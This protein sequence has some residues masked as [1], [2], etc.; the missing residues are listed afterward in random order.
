MKRKKR[1]RKK[2]KRFLF[3]ISIILLLFLL[4]Y[5][6]SYLLIIFDYEKK[7]DVSLGEKFK[8]SIKVTSVFKDVTDNVIIEGNVDTNKLGNYEIIYTYKNILNITKSK[9]SIVSVVDDEAP[10]IELK[11]DSIVYLI[12]NTQYNEQ[13]YI[14]KDNHDEEVEVVIDN[15]IDITTPGIYYIKYVAKDKSNNQKTVKRKVIV[16]EKIDIDLDIK[17]FDINNYFDDNVILKE[18]EDMGNNYINQMV[19]VGDSVPW[20]F[21]LNNMWKSENV[22]AA[23]CT[24]PMNVSYQQVYWKNKA[25][26]KTILELITENQPKYILVSIGFCEIVSSGDINNFISYYDEFISNVKKNSPNTTIILASI[27]PVINETLR[28]NQ[29][30]TNKQVNEYNYYT[31]Y[32]AQK[33]NLKFL[34]YAEVVKNS[35]GMAEATL[36]MDDGYHPNISGMKKIIQYIR[37]HG[38][39]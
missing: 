19:F 23:P 14:V 30:P 1:K 22:Y 7:V 4:I 35:E 10:T 15:E 24:G 18:T 5:I 31:A 27:Y 11:G 29:V 26:K 8:S 25:T 3:I 16:R 39:N 20:Q 21:G 17:S 34:N 2:Q 13:G 12:V 38:Y 28:G 32:V 9:K 6:G 33:N 37:T 36:T